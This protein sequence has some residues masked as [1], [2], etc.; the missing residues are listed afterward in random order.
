MSLLTSAQQSTAR[1]VFGSSLDFSRI[2][3]SD[4]TGLGGL[5]FTMAIN[6]TFIPGLPSGFIQVMNCGTLT[7]STTLLIHE[8]THVWQSQHATSPTQFM[9][10][11]VAGQAAALAANLSSG[12]S[13]HS[14]FPTHFPFST[15]AFLPGSP[16]GDYAAEQI[17]NQV[18]HGITAIVSHVSG[19]AAGAVDADNNTSLATP[20]IE[21]RRLP[22]VIF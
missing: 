17:A 9:G 11:S 4:K 13:S 6:T 2:F 21:D 7:P 20:R 1:G 8:L 16:F 12:A 5:P 22:G 10:N 18:E 14:D 15:Y 3:L 19:V